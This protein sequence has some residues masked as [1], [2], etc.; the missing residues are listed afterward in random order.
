MQQVLSM[1]RFTVQLH[2]HKKAAGQ[3]VTKC[4][5]KYVRNISCLNRVDASVVVSF[6]FTSHTSLYS[7]Q[8]CI[9]VSF[10]PNPR[11]HVK[12][13]SCLFNYRHT[14]RCEVTSLWFWLEFPWWLVMFHTFSSNCRPFVCILWRNV[15]SGPLPE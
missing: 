3:W 7:H 10:S 4:I 1:I 2:L 15:C 12:K 13:I 14:N 8:D 6:F 5:A 11:Q 9:S